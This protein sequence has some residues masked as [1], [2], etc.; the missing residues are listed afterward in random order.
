MVPT[1]T[2]ASMPFPYPYPHGAPFLAIFQPRSCLA[3]QFIPHCP[4]RQNAMP[5]VFPSVIAM[6]LR[7][8]A[9]YPTFRLCPR[10]APPCRSSR[11]QFLPDRRPFEHH[12]APPSPTGRCP[13]SGV[14]HCS[15]PSGL[16]QPA[17]PSSS[18]TG[19]EEEECVP[20]HGRRVR[21]MGFHHP[22]STFPSLYSDVPVPVSCPGPSSDRQDHLRRVADG[23]GDL[24]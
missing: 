19:W 21:G 24:A 14:C 17:S 16:G 15:A 10:R 9:G 1:P 12:S 2:N 5:I 13:P 23:W 18:R 20:P 22:A 11:S 7:V 6:K 4:Y 3:R 8:R